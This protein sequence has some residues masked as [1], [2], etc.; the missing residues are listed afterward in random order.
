[1]NHQFESW[2]PDEQKTSFYKDNRDGANAKEIS[3][4]AKELL[5]N[6]ERHE[7]AYAEGGEYLPLGVWEVRGHNQW[8]HKGQL[9]VFV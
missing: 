8:V 7:D 9:S 6:Y 3:A 2:S 4:L 5:S 1:M